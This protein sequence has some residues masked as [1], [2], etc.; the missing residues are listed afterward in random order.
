[1]LTDEAVEA[2]TRVSI[3]KSAY[4]S[5]GWTGLKREMAIADKQ[6]LQQRRQQVVSMIPGVNTYRQAAQIQQTYEQRGSF[7]GG[8]QIANTTFSLGLDV[9]AVY[10][11]VKGVQAATAPRAAP[12]PAGPAI[13]E[14]SFSVFDWSGYPEGLPRPQGP[15]RLLEGSEY[16]AARKAANQV[17]RAMHRADPSLAGKSIHEIQPVKFGGSPT[18]SANKLPLL[19]AEHA[20]ATAWWNALMRAIQ[21]EANGGS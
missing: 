5:Q 6:D 13:P 20:P 8:V 14:G 15:L 21:G 16:E 9:T 2:Y 12:A 7:A 11:A 10:G 19:P 4:E 17:N 3:A 1:M 18:A